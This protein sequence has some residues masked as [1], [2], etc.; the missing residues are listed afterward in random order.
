MAIKRAFTMAEILITLIIIGTISAITIPSLKKHTTMEEQVTALK[1]A[2][3]VLANATKIVET[4]HGDMKRWGKLTDGDE[5]N[6]TAGGGLGK[7]LDFYS[8]TMNPIKTCKSNETGCWTQTKDLN[9]ATYGGENSISATGVGIKTADG[10]N[11]NFSGIANPESTFGVE[12]GSRES[13]LVWVDTNGDKKPNMLG[14]D[15]FAFIIHPENGILPA[16]I[17]NKS[18]N[19]G[20]GKKGYDCTA[21]VLQSGKIDY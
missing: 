12:K 21:K 10:M 11:W 13:M 1:K 18:A 5:E 16:G 15:V 7:V 19:C 8:K 3:S 9:G 17:K 2:H 6:P 20:K 14:M 4:N